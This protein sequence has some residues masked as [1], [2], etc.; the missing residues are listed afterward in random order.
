MKIKLTIAGMPV[1]LTIEQ[2]KALHAEL[3]RLFCATPIVIERTIPIPY[4]VPA[5]Y[6]PPTFIEPPM[7]TWGAPEITCLQPSSAVA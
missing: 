6:Y 5:P 2:A 7:P 3:A 1:E 4:P